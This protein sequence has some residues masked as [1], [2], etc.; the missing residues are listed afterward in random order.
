MKI[1]IVG[2]AALLL[3]AAAAPAA[4]A[5]T[6]ITIPPAASD[7]TISGIFGDTDIGAG[8]FTDIFTFTLPDGTAAATLSSISTNDTNNVDFTSAD[9]NGH[10]FTIDSTGKVEFR[11]LDDILVTGGPQTLT[12]KGSSGGMG[13]YSGTI[14]FSTAG[15]IGGFGG[16]IP[17]PAA[18]GLMVVGF[19]GLGGM[20]RAKRRLAAVAA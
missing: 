1:A 4:F 5:T 20:L 17:E 7:G 13:A 6:T 10:A 15:R 19:G 18:W 8:A 14:A 16:G 3:A 9:L 11:H 2:A 12:I